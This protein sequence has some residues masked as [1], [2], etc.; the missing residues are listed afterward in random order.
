[1][2]S[3]VYNKSDRENHLSRITGHAA[4]AQRIVI[5]SGWIKDAGVELLAPVLS[6][7][8]KRGATVVVLSNGKKDARQEMSEQG[9]INR[10]CSMGATHHRVC[11]PYL[12][13]KL[14]Y[15]EMPDHHY[16]A[17]IGS[18]NITRGALI[19]NEE[20]STEILGSLQDEQHKQI[21]EYL[22]FLEARLSRR[23]ITVELAGSPTLTAAKLGQLS[24]V[25]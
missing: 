19:E 18:A 16:A 20:L 3:L 22:S 6:D 25:W 5:V 4:K 8:I 2:I 17:L 15:F 9:A 21:R 24:E 12:H 14:H 7:A 1:M 23:N 13:T 10:L 11:K